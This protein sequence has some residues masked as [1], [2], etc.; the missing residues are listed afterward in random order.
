M[1]RC[2]GIE[3]KK[4]FKKKIVLMAIIAHTT[5]VPTHFPFPA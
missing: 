3:M 1:C 4:F 2:D 5:Q